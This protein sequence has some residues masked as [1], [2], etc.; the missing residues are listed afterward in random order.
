MNSDLQHAA[1]R[2][3]RGFLRSWSLKL[4]RAVLAIVAWRLKPI[5]GV[6]VSVHH[7][8]GTPATVR[9]LRQEGVKGA[10][11]VLL[12]IH[13]GG[14]VMVKACM[15]DEFC[16]RLMAETGVAV[17][18]VDYRLAPEHPW[19]AA[20]DDCTAAL[21][22]L[23]QE[24]PAIGLDPSRLVIGGASAGGGLAAA[25][26]LRMVDTGRK[27]PVLQLL[28]YPMIDDRTTLRHQNL[29][30]RLWDETSNRLAWRAYL[31]CEPGSVGVTDLMAPARRTHLKGIPPTWI[32]VGT[33]DLFHDE[34]VRY[35]QALTAAGVPCALEVVEGAFHGFDGVFP[36]SAPSQRYLAAQCAAIT[37]ALNGSAMP[38]GQSC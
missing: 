28:S 9:V 7:L 3:P 8:V 18:S 19:P 21:D 30:V 17:V 37:Q 12:W 14:Y 36:D 38:G 34:D 25:L 13:G 33:E 24:G 2:L 27:L 16:A 1:S 11:P 31:G 10:C 26:V 5:K 32:G 22:F 23:E 6:S 4:V 29:D 20:L 35:A 15:D